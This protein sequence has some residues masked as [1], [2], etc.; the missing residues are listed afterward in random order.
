[1]KGSVMNRYTNRNSKVVVPVFPIP[2]NTIIREST[3]GTTTYEF[4]YPTQQVLQEY[5]QAIEHSPDVAEIR[6]YFSMVLHRVR[7]A[8]EA[9]EQIREAIRIKP[10][11]LYHSRLAD[12]LARR[13]D[14][15]EAV[16]ELQEALRLS[17]MCDT[18]IEWT[19][20]TLRSALCD[21]PLHQNK[22]EEAQEQ[23]ERAIVLMREAISK[24]YGNQRVLGQ[25]RNQLRRCKAL[26][27]HR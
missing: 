11:Y 14:H 26:R 27:S 3:N 7:R 10:D 8:D 20:A 19:E 5:Q 16:E 21:V 17:E 18:A 22:K 23:I 1:M 12:L 25:M 15:D 9:I 4:P 6:Y 13:G 2:S 24:G